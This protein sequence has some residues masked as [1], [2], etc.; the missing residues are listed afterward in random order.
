MGVVY[1]RKLVYLELGGIKSS[2]FIVH[3]GLEGTKSSYFSARLGLLGD[4]CSCFIVHLGLGGIK[5]SHFIVHLGLAGTKSSYF[6]ARLGGRGAKSSYFYA[7]VADFVIVFMELSYIYVGPAWPWPKV[8]K[9]CF[10]VALRVFL[11]ETRSLIVTLL[12]ANTHTLLTPS[13]R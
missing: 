8:R 3:L 9:C 4:K 10:K 7:T 6:I 1:K 5:S 12:L 2:Y 11:A 13:M